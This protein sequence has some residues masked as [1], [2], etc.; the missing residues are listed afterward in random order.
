MKKT[1]PRADCR[2]MKVLVT[3]GAGFIGSNLVRRLLEDGVQT[4][5]VIDDF[6][7]GFRENLKD[8]DVDIF[9]GSILDRDLL[10]RAVEGSDAIVHLA[11]RPSVPRSIND[12]VASHHANATGTL[13]V[14]EAARAVGAHV[15]VASSSS[16]YGANPILPKSEDLRP[17]PISPYAVSKLATETYALSY[18]HVYELETIAFRFFNVYGPRQAA[19][20]AYAA[21]IPSFLESALTSIPLTIHGDGEQT[22]DF[23]FV[24]TVTEVLSRAAR[25]RVV[26]TDPVN[27]AFGTRHRL[28]D[29]IGLISQ[30][31][32]SDL[33]LVHTTPRAGD[34]RDSQATSAQLSHYFPG[35]VPVPLDVGLSKTIDWF[36]STLR[37]SGSL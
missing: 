25:E 21:A 28:L 1:D 36:Q 15:S 27:L 5:T 26:A 30:R 24:D 11:A 34:V 4:V 12:P 29:V 2:L 8:V 10:E 7:T 22:R 6:S 17:M 14:L 20:H 23:T 13:Y 3:G 35:T 32:G 9:E 31:L 37:D 19:G 33:Q 18:H 16:V